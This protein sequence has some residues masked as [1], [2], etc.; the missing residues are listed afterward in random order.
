MFSNAVKTKLRITQKILILHPDPWDKKRHSKRR[1][2]Q[3]DFID[4]LSIILKKNGIIT[5]A[6]DNKIMTSWIL[7]QFH[8]RKEFIWQVKSINNCLKKPKNFLET[9]Y[10]QNLRLFFNPY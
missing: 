2:L 9:K 7:E 3:Q 6:S 4:C 10:F 1:L 5:F 8:F